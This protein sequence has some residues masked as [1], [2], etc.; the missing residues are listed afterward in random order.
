MEVST[1]LNHSY[2]NYVLTCF[3]I[4]SL[5]LIISVLKNDG[6]TR[7]SFHMTCHHHQNLVIIMIILVFIGWFL[8]GFFLSCIIIRLHVSIQ[9][10]TSLQDLFS[11]PTF[12]FFLIQSYPNCFS[13]S[14]FSHIWLSMSSSLFILLRRR[15]RLQSHSSCHWFKGYHQ[16][17]KGWC[18]S[19]IM[20][21]VWIVK[22]NG[23]QF[24]ATFVSIWYSFL[25]LFMHENIFSFLFSIV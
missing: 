22:M 2:F 9:S 13:S 6:R 15:C 12:P 24:I 8:F 10:P 11:I 20:C 21:L 16:L 19:L 25:A 17:W 18:E 7:S 5:L 4:W 3:Q 1:L 14:F 23:I